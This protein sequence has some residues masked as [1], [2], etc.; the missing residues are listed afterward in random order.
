MIPSVGIASSS[1]ALRSERSAWGRRA[2]LVGMLLCGFGSGI[3]Q[4]AYSTIIGEI[5]ATYGVSLGVASFALLGMMIFV[6]AIGVPIAG[7]LADRFGV[8]RVLIGSQMLFVASFLAL[9]LLA[10]SFPLLVGSRAIQGLC[11][12]GVAGAL[13][14]AMSRYFPPEQIGRAMGIQT[15]GLPLGMLAGLLLVPRLT[16][17]AGDWRFGLAYLGVFGGMALLPIVWGAR[18]LPREPGSAAAAAKIPGFLKEALELPLF[19]H[20]VVIS[21]LLYATGFTLTDLAPGFLA[22]APPVG[23]G[24]GPQRAGDLVSL[25]MLS[26]LGAPLLA[27]FLVDRV[28]DGRVKAV[29]AIGWAV[30][31]LPPLLV[32]PAIHQSPKLLSVFLLLGGFAQPFVSI[33]LMTSAAR[34]FPKDVV[35]SIAGLWLCVSFLSAALGTLLGSLGLHLTGRYILP[36]AVVWIGNLIGLTCALLAKDPVSMSGPVQ[37]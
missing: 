4:I 32:L 33:T 37:P 29:M 2:L 23:V 19:R 6:M 11:A 20:G 17:A 7:V 14:P 3:S 12:A 34:V 22:V 27:G 10:H 24:L 28:F 1:Y 8:F 15:M 35:G 30:A 18:W 9:P 21:I 25:L 5:A 36:L 26:G 31:L 13:T 16:Q